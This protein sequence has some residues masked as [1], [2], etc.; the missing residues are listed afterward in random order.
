MSL[1]FAALP[2]EINSGRMYAGPGSASIR[3]AAAAW[4]ELAAGLQSAAASYAS[5]ISGLTGGPWLGP[6]SISMAAAATAHAAWISATAGQAAQAQV[7]ASAAA[8]AYEAAFAATVPPPAIAANRAQ[9]LSLIATNFVGQNCPAIAATNAQYAEMWAQDAAAMCGYVSASAAASKLTPFN[10]P[11]R[12]AGLA[13]L[14][15]QSAVVVAAGQR[16]ISALPHALR[17]LA[18]LPEYPVYDLFNFVSDIATISSLPVSVTSACVGT[19]NS[20]VSLAGH[21][22]QVGAEAAQSLGAGLGAI[23]LAGLTAPAAVSADVGRA[24][25]VGALS[26]PPSWATAPPTLSG[27]GLPGTQ[28]GAAPMVA[29]GQPGVP[30]LPMPATWARTGGSSPPRYGLRFTVMARPFAAG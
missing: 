14:A 11:H 4:G 17:G 3:A 24:V 8:A 26:V 9:L 12:I 28:V 1:D 27:A 21:T 19:I 13:G 23:G 18:S 20:L 6:A 10:A 29:A 16:A 30:G 25:T 22:A 5:V 15:E 2:P 7:Q